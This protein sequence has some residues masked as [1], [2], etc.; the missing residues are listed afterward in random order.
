LHI[1]FEHTKVPVTVNLINEKKYKF[2]IG[3]FSNF[4]YWKN[5]RLEINPIGNF[6]GRPFFQQKKLDK[7]PIGFSKVSQTTVI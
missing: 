7:N 1:H 2:P 3:F 4:F 5:V 6:S